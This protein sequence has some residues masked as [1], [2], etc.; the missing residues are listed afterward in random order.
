MKYNSIEEWRED[1]D[2]L[3]AN[4]NDVHWV[5]TVAERMG[6]SSDAIQEQI[7]ET[8]ENAVMDENP[9]GFFKMVMRRLPDHEKYILIIKSHD[10][11]WFD[12]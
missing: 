10:D 9:I 5:A 11:P 6:R 12:A 3:E 1:M 4:P 8:I 2:V 7:R